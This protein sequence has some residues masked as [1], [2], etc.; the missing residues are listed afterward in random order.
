ME[1]GEKIDARCITIFK[2]LFVYQNIKDLAQFE[3]LYMQH[4]LPKF[5]NY[6][7]LV[8]ITITDFTPLLQ[9]MPGGME[10]TKF[11]IETCFKSKEAFEQL[12]LADEGKAELAGLLK[13]PNMDTSIFV[14]EDRTFRK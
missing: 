8:S 4:V 5:V 9:P 12:I 13:D 1:S 6:E 3:K 14:V 7:G 10:G 11:S 2:V